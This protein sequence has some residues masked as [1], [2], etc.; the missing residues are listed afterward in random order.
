MNKPSKKR[1]CTK[2]DQGRKLIRLSA[3]SRERSHLF[4]C[5][6][7]K[8]YVDANLVPAGTSQA[9]KLMT[10]SNH[11]KN[12]TANWIEMATKGNQ[13][14]VLPHLTSG[15]VASNKIYYHDKCYGTI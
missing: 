11:V 1:K 10:K 14:P 7:S 13:K 2:D 3:E 12:L 9:T 4:C 15:D 5:W 6:C 8:K